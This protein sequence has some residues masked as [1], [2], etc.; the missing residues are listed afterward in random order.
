MPQSHSKIFVL[1]PFAMGKDPLFV[2]VSKTWSIVSSPKVNTVFARMWHLI[3]TPSGTSSIPV[4][5]LT[6]IVVHHSSCNEC[7][8]LIFSDW[9]IWKN[10]EG[11]YPGDG[12][13]SFEES[14]EK[15]IITPWLVEFPPR[16]TNVGVVL[17]RH[18]KACA[19]FY[20]ASKT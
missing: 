6:E 4:L 16:T 12:G 11:W 5:R 3:D 20:E 1:F 8:D 18:E 15:A 19:K 7:S 2:F 13:E 14:E 10:G 17:H 9:R